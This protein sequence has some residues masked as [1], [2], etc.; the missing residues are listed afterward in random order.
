MLNFSKYNNIIINSCSP[1]ALHVDTNPKNSH[2]HTIYTKW[3]FIIIQFLVTIICQ[4]MKLKLWIP[5]IINLTFPSSCIYNA[6]IS[7]CVLFWG[8]INILQY[9]LVHLCDLLVK[10]HFFWYLIMK[11]RIVDNDWAKWLC[12]C[13]ALACKGGFHVY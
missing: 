13:E 8:N 2:I 9:L 7:H 6:S 1:L 4:F 10:C 3:N 5:Y 12:V 11:R